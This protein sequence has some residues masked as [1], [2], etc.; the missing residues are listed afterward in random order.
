MG[1]RIFLLIKNVAAGLVSEVGWGALSVL[2]GVAGGGGFGEATI[3]GGGGGP[4]E[5]LAGE[6]VEATTAAVS[7]DAGVCSSTWVLGVA[8]VLLTLLELGASWDTSLFLS[9]P[10]PLPLN[11]AANLPM[12]CLLL[13]TPTVPHI[14]PVR[15]LTRTYLSV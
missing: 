3:A 2:V 10:F 5:A 12:P 11:K 4:T 1:P 15:R 7:G 6:E 9:F 13:L 8:S 14:L